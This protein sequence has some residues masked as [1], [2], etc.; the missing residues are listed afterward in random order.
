M[1]ILAFNIRCSNYYSNIIIINNTS[2]G[3][4]EQENVTGNKR[5]FSQIER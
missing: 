2:D 5:I 3:Y 1:G 4:Q